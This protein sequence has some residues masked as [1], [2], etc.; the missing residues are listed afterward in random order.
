[1]SAS[2]ES[3]AASRRQDDERLLQ[4][5]AQLAPD[6]LLARLDT[7]PDGLSEAEARRRLSRYGTNALRPA[8]RLPVL[9]ELLRMLLA[10]LS[11]LLIALASASW[12][13]GETRGA[14]VILAMVLLAAL[15][16]F[17]QQRRAGMAAARLRA[18]V[19][20]RAEVLRDGRERQ[21]DVTHIVPGDIVHL[22]V[23]DIVPA[24]LCLLDSKDL[25]VDQAALSGESLP[26]EK[27]HEPP[28]SAVRSALEARNLC[29]MGSHVV[30]GTGHGVVLRTGASTLFGQL[31]AQTTGAQ[32]ETA[33]D[34]GV[35]RFTVLMVRFMAVMVPAVLLINGFGRGDWLE[36]ALFAIAIA[37]GLTPEMLPML[38]TVNLARGA[39]ALSRR[40]VIVKTLPSVQNLGAMDVLCTDKTG[41]LTQN[42]VVLERH[43]DVNGE[44]DLGVLEFAYLN[45]H[46]QSGLRNLLDVAVLRHVEV[47]E[48]LHGL[49]SYRRVDEIPF[50]FERRRMSVVVERCVDDGSAQ[51]NGRSHILVCKGAV[52]EVMA[53]CS[54]ARAGGR[55]MPLDAATRNRLDR[56]VAGLNAEGFRVIAVA[57]R[58]APAEPRAYTVDDEGGLTLLGYIAF[59]DPPKESAGPALAALREAGVTVRILTGDSERVTRK[60]CHDVGLEVARIVSGAETEGLDDPA[61]AELA[62]SV[63]VFVKMTPMQKA[64]VIRA[65]RSRGHVVGY[66]GDGINDGPGLR[67][68]DIGISVDSAVD[69]AR[70]S[71]DIILL[72]K[73]L[74]V[75]HQGVLEGRRVFANLVKY[76][77]MSASSSFGNMFSMLGASAL[78]PFLPMAPVHVLLNNL[79]YDIS[80]VAVP[81][82]TVDAEAL[83]KPRDWDI[84]G[85]Q[86]TMLLI[87]PVSSLFD[88]ATFGLM[89]FAFGATS[90]AEAPLFQTGWF[91]ESLL[92][93][94]LIVHVLRTER[95]PFVESAP[96]PALLATTLGVCGSGVLLPYTPLG[97]SLGLVPLPAAYW[98]AMTALLL[99]YFGLTQWVKT[100]LARQVRA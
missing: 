13:T 86:R 2:S 57:M 20:T 21:T 85:I 7:R 87:G 53:C 10:P 1:M 93:Q 73:S 83:R 14:V 47:H 84:A 36:A 42:R 48:R 100:R 54:L 91:V 75:L 12:F 78:L 11:V 97:A 34:R 49:G 82:D 76:I 51:Q 23:G 40:K 18:M 67:A 65:L 39:L 90:P 32:T 99:A 60:V 88:Y 38:V 41:T 70:E 80:Q 94:T 62:G 35:S 55:C 89:W 27:H 72:E 44:P 66:L 5:F 15:L 28:L 52:E 58:E 56:V 77:R 22:A 31:A 69:I 30:S 68:A 95:V 63:P 79:L 17:V 29:L 59:F 33:F 8:R 19:S 50:D 24:D 4:A 25:F 6:A 45:S 9:L 98:L 3:K 46:Y 81:A 61:L 74:L 16:G 26:A 71:A 37:V 92:S 43:V 64:R 96:A